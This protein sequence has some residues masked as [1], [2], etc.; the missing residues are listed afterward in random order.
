MDH[1]NELSFE[2]LPLVAE[3][4]RLSTRLENYIDAVRLNISKARVCVEDDIFSLI[5]IQHG[6]DDKSEER[7]EHLDILKSTIFIYH[8][9]TII[10]PNISQIDQFKFSTGVTSILDEI[11]VWKNRSGSVAQQYANSFKP[12]QLILDTLEERSLE[13]MTTVVESLEDTCDSLWNSQ[14]PY[15]ENRMK[16]LIQCMGISICEQWEL[17]VRLLTGQTWPRQ[18]D[19][20]WQGDLVEMKFLHGFKKRLEEVRSLKLLSSEISLLLNDKNVESEVEKIIEIAMKN[21]DVLAYNPFTESA[22]RSRVLVAERALDPLIELAIPVLKSRLQ[23]DKLDNHYLTADLQKYKNFF[24]RTNIKEKLYAERYIIKATPVPN[25]LEK[26]RTDPCRVL[27][28]TDR[29]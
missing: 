24:M 19:N 25:I 15:P 8:S 11:R 12:L 22:W 6:D 4:I 9:K 7:K 28:P 14:P 20:P 5:E 17:S 21:T 3:Y 27:A 29:T 13:E 18:L 16:S 10:F 23:P 26:G 1:L 2:R